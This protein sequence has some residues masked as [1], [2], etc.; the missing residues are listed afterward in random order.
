[1]ND[2]FDSKKELLRALLWAYLWLPLMNVVVQTAYFIILLGISESQ[3][4]IIAQIYN[5]TLP[6]SGVFVT[7]IFNWQL[8]KLFLA[9]LIFRYV[10]FIIY[11]F[12]APIVRFAILRKPIK[13][14]SLAL[15]GAL[16]TFGVGAMTHAAVYAPLLDPKAGAYNLIVQVP[17]YATMVFAFLAGLSLLRCQTSSSKGRWIREEEPHARTPQGAM[18]HRQ[19]PPLRLTLDDSFSDMSTGSMSGSSRGSMGSS[20]NV[21]AEDSSGVI[22]SGSAHFGTKGEGQLGTPAAQPTA[23]AAT[24]QPQPMQSQGAFAQVQPAPQTAVTQPAQAWP[25]SSRAAVLDAEAPKPAP[26]PAPE[27]V[28]QAPGGLGGVAASFQA[29][30]ADRESAAS[31]SMVKDTEKS[32]SPTY[33]AAPPSQEAKPLPGD[34][35]SLL[36]G[37]DSAKSEKT[38]GGTTPEAA[39]AGERSLPDD[40]AALLKEIQVAEPSEEGVDEM[41]AAGSSFQSEGG[42]PD[43]LA[44]LLKEIQVTERPE[45]ESEEEDALPIPTLEQLLSNMKSQPENEPAALV[46]EKQEP[47]EQETQPQEEQGIQV[48]SEPLPAGDETLDAE[49]CLLCGEGTVDAQ[50]LILTNGEKIHQGCYDEAVG[51]MSSLKSDEETKAFF[52]SSPN[53]MKVLFMMNAGQPKKESQEPQE[54]QGNAPRARKAADSD[55]SG[56]STPGK[57]KAQTQAPEKKKRAPRKTIK[58]ASDESD[59]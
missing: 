52:E 3:G 6:S 28:A 46:E 51:R 27:A 57:G 48:V 1:M 49:K 25:D 16:L 43:D 47:V 26:T 42:L 13:R 11:T 38:P 30:T 18:P 14:S 8:G 59:D 39:A 58:K 56:E 7:Q 2:K 33:P 23:P 31:W 41:S 36:V 24:F 37:T 40:L 22:I 29:Q 32:P 4:S 12:P 44:A 53:L 5:L 17:E 55:K 45:E 19:A 35:A 21:G 50:C 34:L 54:K 10:S 9:D 20:M 15:L